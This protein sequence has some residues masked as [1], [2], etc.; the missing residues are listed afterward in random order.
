MAWQRQI[1]VAFVSNT[2]AVIWFVFFTVAELLLEMPAELHSGAMF[3]DIMRTAME[4]AR[5]K[6]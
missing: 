1:C 4:A 5:P 6:G 3:E 2:I